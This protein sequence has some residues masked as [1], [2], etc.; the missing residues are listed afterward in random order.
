[1]HRLFVLSVITLLSLAGQGNADQSSRTHHYAFNAD[2][3]LTD[4]RQRS[5]NPDDKFYVRIETFKS[6]V[7]E[8]HQVM[9]IAGTNIG[10]MSVIG[11]RPEWA[12]SSFSFSGRASSANP[13][14]GLVGVSLSLRSVIT[15]YWTGEITMR[16]STKPYRVRRTIPVQCDFPPDE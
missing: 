8:P 9:T 7:D 12:K 3:T 10:P 13:E 2:C 6:P 4:G 5:D 11:I 16:E 1:M 14:F 15:E